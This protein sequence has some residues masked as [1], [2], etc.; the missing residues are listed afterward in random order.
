MK[1]CSLGRHSLWRLPALY[2]VCQSS[3]GG[4]LRALLL[5]TELLHTDMFL[6]RG[7]HISCIGTTEI[8]RLHCTEPM[9]TEIAPVKHSVS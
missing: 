4:G 5:S 9:S 3:M 8:T 2:G 1:G 7:S 6:E